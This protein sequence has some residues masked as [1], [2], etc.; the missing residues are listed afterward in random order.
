MSKEK[1]PKWLLKREGIT[2]R[3]WKSLKRTELRNVIKAL[4]IY[5]S[6]CAFCPGAREFG[7]IVSALDQLEKSHSVKEWGR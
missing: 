2:Q 7:T 3:Q 4:D 5:R 6:G 1:A